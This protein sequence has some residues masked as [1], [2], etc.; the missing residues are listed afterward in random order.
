MFRDTDLVRLL[1]P[2]VADGW[3]TGQRYDFQ[4]GDLGAVVTPG[5]DH[6]QAEFVVQLPGGG[7]ECTIATLDRADA[8]VVPRSEWPRPV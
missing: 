3:E 2:I 1:R 8:E 5:E 4:P 6:C 7:I